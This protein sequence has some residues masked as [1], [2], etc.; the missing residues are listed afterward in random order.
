MGSWLAVAGARPNFVKLAPLVRAARA[1]GRDL[2]WVHTGQHWDAA[3]SADLLDELGLPRPVAHL[4]VGAGTPSAQAA[5]ILDRLPAVLER[6]RPSVVVVLGDV[7]ST[8][9]AALAAS[10]AGVPVAHVEAGLRSGDWSMPEERNRVLVD[11]ASARLYVPEAA[12]VRHLAREGI[13]GDGVRLVGDVVADALRAAGPAIAGRRVPAGDFGLVTLHRA[14]NV[15]DPAR[16]EAWCRGLATAARRLPLV[17][18][19]HPRTRARLAR[20]GNARRLREGGVR[21]VAPLGHLDFLAHLAHSRA[22][23]TDSGSV[24]VEASCLGVPCLSLRA[25]SERPLTLSVGTNR[26]VGDDPRR[27]P[28]AVER[29]LEAPRPR[30]TRVAAWDGRASERVVRDLVSWIV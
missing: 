23:L 29:A 4:A 25:T 9:A 8:L 10:Q 1:A 18:P 19:V 14:A 17:F 2:P 26:L 24:P 13:R 28:E 21:V 11:R 15:D 16:L 7:T 6:R 22:V 30:G 20:G 12:G 27:L 3:M 5:R